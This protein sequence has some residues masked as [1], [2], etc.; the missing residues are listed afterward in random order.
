MMKK[1]YYTQIAGLGIV[2]LILL[3]FKNYSKAE[4]ENFPE[5]K[6]ISENSPVL[7][8]TDFDP[9]DLNEEQWQHLG[10]SS[11]QIA[12]ILNYKKMIGG[13]F[14]SKEQFKKCFAVS[15]EKYSELETY[16][17]LPENNKE[18]TSNKFKNFEK[19]AVTI[20]GRFNPDYYSA[21][22][23]IQMGFSEKQAD[24]ILKYK[25]Y[26]GGSFVSKE[27]F[28]ECF[29]ISEENF[30]KMSPYLILPEKAPASFTHYSKNNR[31]EKTNIQYHLFD[32]NTLDLEGWKSFGFSDKQ[33]QTIINYR[34][35]N[36]KGSFKSLED[37]QKCFVI[38]DKKFEEMK[39]FIRLSSAPNNDKIKQQEK[40]DFSK[41]D[42]NAITFKQLIE[43]GF[44]EKA[45]GSMIGFR[46]KLGGFVNKEQILTTY[47]IDPE[48]TEKLLAIAQLNTSNV[49]KYTLT[50]APEEWLRN[51]PY[52]K[53]SADKIIYYRISNPN[54]RKIWKYLKLKPEYEAR[55]RLYTK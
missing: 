3:A 53:Y 40:T 52:F 12:T 16:I 45:A 6:F 42:L 19:R 27:K 1:S 33:S 15:A 7:S 41:V 8:L 13:R 22:D 38:S 23:W 39:P 47:N 26:L 44:D 35:R 30:Q 54:D 29:I 9:N 48:L 37:L 11:K 46:K 36:L 17:L 20:S 28:K 25:K 43:F 21:S 18:A 55:M 2:L 31:F 49:Q 51:H 34:D 10:F 32:P 14:I 5:I 50:E 4:S 24:A